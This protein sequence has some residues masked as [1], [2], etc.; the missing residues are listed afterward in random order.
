MRGYGFRSEVP[1]VHVVLIS[2]G[3]VG[4]ESIVD[5]TFECPVLKRL[6]HTL[7]L[8]HIQVY[9]L[10]NV[11]NQGIRQVFPIIIPA[12]EAVHFISSVCPL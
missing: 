1:L 8:M 4:S 9:R 3:M 10:N 2:P 7:E 11:I 12:L 6:M 5:Q